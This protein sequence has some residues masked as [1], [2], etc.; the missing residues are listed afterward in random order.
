M[1]QATVSFVKGKGNINHNNRK[2]LTNNVDRDRVKDNII[3][4]QKDLRK[5]Y[6]DIFQDS[7]DEYNSKQKRADRKIDSYYDKIEKSKQENLFYEIVVQVGDKDFS[8]KSSVI[9]VLNDYMISFEERNPTLKVFNAVMHLDEET[10][11]LH[12][13]FVPVSEGYKKGLAKR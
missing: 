8:D 5:F 11:H 4:V 2:F 3:Y 9:D 1:K 6:K 7:V 12:I 10:P 13:D